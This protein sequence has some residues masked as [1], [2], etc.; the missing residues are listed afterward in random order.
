MQLGHYRTSAGASPNLCLTR[1]D[2]Q[3]R[4]FK[5]SSSTLFPNLLIA[6]SVC[7]VE[8][9]WADKTCSPSSWASYTFKWQRSPHRCMLG[10]VISLRW[11]QWENPSCYWGWGLPPSR[12]TFTVSYKLCLLFI[13]VRWFF[14]L[15]FAS[16]SWN[17]LYIFCFQSS[18]SNSAHPCATCSWKYCYWRWHADS[19][20][21]YTYT[22]IFL[23]TPNPPPYLF[24][25]LLNFSSPG[26]S[27]EFITGMVLF[28]LKPI[29]YSSDS[30][31]LILEDGN[32]CTCLHCSF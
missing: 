25:L 1:F 7:A 4:L 11:I 5:C 14:F 18:I 17:A 16:E 9:Q 27:H 29:T 10:T 22:F 13:C 24:F 15:A 30:F 23:I 12:W 20:I 2:F 26:F 21:G 28:I 31:V 3:D 32:T 19:G 8:I 6:A